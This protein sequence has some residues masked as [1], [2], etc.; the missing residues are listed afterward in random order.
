[1]KKRRKIDFPWVTFQ[2]D[3]GHYCVSSRF[4]SSI[5]LENRFQ[6]LPDHT[7]GLMG[8][9]EMHESIVPVFDMRVLLGMRS[10]RE[11]LD[12]LLSLMDEPAQWLRELESCVESGSIF[13]IPVHSKDSAFGKWYGGFETANYNLRFLL[14]KII[15]LH[16]RLYACGGE[17]KLALEDGESAQRIQA[18]MKEAREMNEQL[19]PLLHALADAYTQANAGILIVL[20]AGGKKM[21]VHVDEISGVMH[22]DKITDQSS[23]ETFGESPYISS[24][25]TND[26][27]VYLQLDLN[28]LMELSK[29]A[30]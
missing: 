13:S 22:F 9:I 24:L 28:T 8:V 25:I 3:G 6:P 10:M 23:P 1:M 7:P 30:A 17:I 15:P 26:G 27:I 20:E 11:I 16:Q 4:V 21:G 12:D 14:K 5:M 29:Q 19:T 18:A 2:V